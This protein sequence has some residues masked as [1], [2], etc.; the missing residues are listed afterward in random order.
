MPF[1]SLWAQGRGS[2]IKIKPECVIYRFVG[3]SRIIYKIMKIF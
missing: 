2:K 3:M 1:K